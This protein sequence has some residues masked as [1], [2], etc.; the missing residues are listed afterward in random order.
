MAVVL[1]DDLVFEVPGP[2]WRWTPPSNPGVAVLGII[3]IFF[4]PLDDFPVGPVIGAKSVAV[5]ALFPLLVV[6]AGEGLGVQRDD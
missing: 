4:T 2:W 5:K 3:E 6:F 1:Q